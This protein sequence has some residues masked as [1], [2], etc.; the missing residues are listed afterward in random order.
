MVEDKIEH[1]TERA[2][3]L[4]ETVTADSSADDFDIGTVLC[5]E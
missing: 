3:C 2:E 1:L 4:A 5:G